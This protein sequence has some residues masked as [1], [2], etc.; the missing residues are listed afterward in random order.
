VNPEPSLGSGEMFD[1]IADRYDLLNRILSFGIDVRWRTKAIRSLGLDGAGRI[2]DVATGTADVAIAAAR[3]GL[4]VV[5]VDPSAGMLAVGREKVTR[6]KLDDRVELTL[7]SAEALPFP[8]ESFD[9][10][11][12]AFGIRNVPD[13]L[14]GVAEMRRVVK[15]GGRVVVLELGE[16]Q[17][18]A[19]GR[20]ARFHVHTVVPMIG[21]L[22]SGSR[23][24]AYLQRSIAAFPPA[25]EFAETM[26][27]TGLAVEAVIP[28]TFGVAH[29][30]VTRRPEAV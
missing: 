1:R 29:L 19:L 22:V 14:R 17:G 18:A 23:E 27:S 9:G 8:A 3:T 10:S 2:L 15:P 11:I 13:R 28:L 20:L 12:I 26:A 21:G 5:G 6:A 4:C 25:D 24:Y 30:Y 16:P 7:G